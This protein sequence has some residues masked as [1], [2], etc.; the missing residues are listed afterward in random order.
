MRSSS[1][2]QQQIRSRPCNLGA[3]SYATV[4]M[5][6]AQL[7]L[8]DMG[9]TRTMLLSCALLVLLM[10]SQPE[11]SHAAWQ[12][13]QGRLSV[14][15]CQAP[16]CSSAP[17]LCAPQVAEVCSPARCVHRAGLQ[18]ST[19]WC[20]AAGGTKHVLHPQGAH[21]HVSEGETPSTPASLHH[22]APALDG[23]H[24]GWLLTVPH[25]DHH[26]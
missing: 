7:G 1:C 5:H 17:A 24:P 21:L 8:E 19:I 11:T 10:H 18:T 2:T 3:A 14:P 23:Q 13:E 9:H 26:A 22:A 25:T 15:C 20:S 6:V 16:A 12:P 4:C